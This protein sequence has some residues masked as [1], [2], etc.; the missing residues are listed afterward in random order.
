MLAGT[1]GLDLRVDPQNVKEAR[2][3]TASGRESLRDLKRRDGLRVLALTGSR[4]TKLM[5]GER[6]VEPA[7]D[8]ARGAKFGVGVPA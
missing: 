4:Q 7:G 8:G 3:V 1:G 2:F 6:M 5:V